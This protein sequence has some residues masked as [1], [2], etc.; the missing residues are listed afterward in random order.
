MKREHDKELM[1]INIQHKKQLKEI[2]EK[3]EGQEQIEKKS[4]ETIAELKD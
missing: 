1:T 2:E 3:G 4:Q